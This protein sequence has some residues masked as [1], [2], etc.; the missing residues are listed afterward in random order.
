MRRS[1]VIALMLLG[2]ALVAATAQ[3]AVVACQSQQELEQ[4]I[5]S[6]GQI[7]PDGCRNVS[8]TPLDSDGERLCLMDFAED[9]E[10]IVSQLREA[11]V[12][13]EWWVRCSDLNP[14]VPG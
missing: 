8:I 2:P 11:A 4:V 5:A 14:A 7:L 6:D 12:N 3:E 1:T 13:E 10:G 9:G